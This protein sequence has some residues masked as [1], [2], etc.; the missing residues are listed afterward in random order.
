[1]NRELKLGARQL[2]RLKAKLNHKPSPFI[3]KK[4]KDNIVGFSVQWSDVS[5]LDESKSPV[6]G[7]VA[8]TSKRGYIVMADVYNEHQRYIKDTMQLMWKI[9]ISAVYE[10]NAA[11]NLVE[12]PIRA[13]G[14]IKDLDSRCSAIVKDCMSTLDKKNYKAVIFRCECIGLHDTKKSEIQRL[15][16]HLGAI[17]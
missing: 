9:D 4:I 5:P 13:F 12:R 15:E 3:L 7:E 17:A 2:R 14:T 10:F 11:V 8:H 1:M 6:N 16:S